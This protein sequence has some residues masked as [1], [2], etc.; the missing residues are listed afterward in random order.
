MSKYDNY[1]Y[2]DEVEPGVRYVTNERTGESFMQYHGWVTEGALEV[3]PDQ[4]RTARQKRDRQAQYYRNNADLKMLGDFSFVA[5]DTRFGDLLPA[6]MARLIYLAT[7]LEYNTGRIMQTS[8]LPLHRC[9]LPSFLDI[10]K[11]SA[12]RLMKE[13]AP[14]YI[15]KDKDGILYLNV[16]YFRRG[17]LE[18]GG[19]GKYQKAYVKTIRQLY[20]SLDQS[21]HKHLGYV[22]QMLPYVHI[23]YNILCRNITERCIEDID[24]ISATEF[25]HMIGYDVSALSRLKAIY[26]G[27]RFA[28]GDKVEPFCAFVDVGSTTRIVVN[29]H[30]LYSGRNPGKVEALGAFF[31]DA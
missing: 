11:T 26:R 28:V 1:E 8:R 20:R 23:E 31:P 27:I 16:E 14:K 3:M 12:T 29:P 15:T 18:D 6:T 13:A 30:I 24:H 4:L 10:S 22:F 21:K 17:A 19:T 2:S 5:S 9:D 7:F 25:C